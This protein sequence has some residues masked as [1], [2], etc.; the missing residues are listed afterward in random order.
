MVIDGILV[1]EEDFNALGFTEEDLKIW[2]NPMVRDGDVPA[3]QDEAERKAA[4]LHKRAMVRDFFL[5]MRHGL[6]DA[7]DLASAV[8]DGDDAGWR[9]LG[10]DA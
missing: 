9:D 8:F 10:H 3:K 6:L 1:P 7:L 2:S 4:F 5:E